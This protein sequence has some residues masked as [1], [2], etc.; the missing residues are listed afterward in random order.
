MTDQPD[1]AAIAGALA[2]DD[3]RQAFAAVQLGATTLHDVVAATGLT[4][5]RASRALGRLADI[6]LMS[7]GVDGGLCVAG[8]AFQQA[9]RAA[10]ARLPSDEHADVPGAARRVL[11][12]FVHAGRVERLPASR[13]KRRVVLD[14]L[15][16]SFEPGRHYAEAEVNAILEE[17][18]T[19]FVTT[20][21]YLVDEGFLDRAGGQ[22]WRAGGSVG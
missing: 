7:R 15:A 5:A 4:P 21:R 9:A 13:S 18:T 6:G 2:D 11:D 8:F 14:W 20:R 16:Q 3:R 12:A 10:L 19:D 22:Y 17:H 1:A